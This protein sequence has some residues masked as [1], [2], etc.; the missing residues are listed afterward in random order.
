MENSGC[1]IGERVNKKHL[2]EASKKYLDHGETIIGIFHGARRPDIL[3]INIS[4]PK[5]EQRSRGLTLHDYLILTN[6]RVILWMRGLLSSNIETIEYNEINNLEHHQ[7]IF[8][9]D[10]TFNI[11][12]ARERF[13]DMVKKDVPIAARM[14]LDK[15][16]V[17]KKNQKQDQTNSDNPITILKMRFAKGEINKNEYAE[18]LKELEKR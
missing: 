16:D 14:I 3:G 12:G 15:I 10:I 6:K 7:G 17:A 5:R 13:R 9:G 18:I 2:E 4:D 1:Y 11:H 8:L